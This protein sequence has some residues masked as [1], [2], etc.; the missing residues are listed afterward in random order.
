[1]L[2]VSLI[3]SFVAA[4]AKDVSWQPAVILHSIDVLEAI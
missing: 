3:R 1:M 4:T 2:R